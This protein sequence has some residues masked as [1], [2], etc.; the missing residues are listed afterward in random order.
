MLML[1][2]FAIWLVGIFFIPLLSI[3]WWYHFTDEAIVWFFKTYKKANAYLSQV[4]I[5]KIN[6]YISIGLLLAFMVGMGTIVPATKSETAVFLRG[7]VGYPTTMVTMEL[8]DISAQ[9]K[10]QLIDELTPWMQH[11]AKKLEHTG[12]YIGGGRLP[13]TAT[14]T[15]YLESRY[16]FKGNILEIIMGRDIPV[17]ELQPVLRAF[18]TQQ[19]INDLPSQHLAEL[20]LQTYRGFINIK[21]KTIRFYH[22]N[23][24]RGINACYYTV[25]AELFSH[26][27]SVFSSLIRKA[28]SKDYSSNASL[29]TGAGWPGGEKV[30]PLLRYE[31]IPSN[32]ISNV[33]NIEIKLYLLPTNSRFA[34]IYLDND[35]CFELI[36]YGSKTIDAVALQQLVPSRRHINNITVS[37]RHFFPWMDAGTL[38]NVGM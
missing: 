13:R 38:Q 27:L 24:E 17:A 10:K 3:T 6:K 30:Y 12:V 5:Q 9:Q 37:R 7:L 22:R 11:G 18:T 32:S 35:S 34:N 28:P 4:F 21:P 23:E 2:T 1:S 16:R 29:H 19:G 25:Q 36:K 8:E 14:T 33:R 15:A 31:Q 20:R 26:R